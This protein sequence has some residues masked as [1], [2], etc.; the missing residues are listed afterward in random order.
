M[1]NNVLAVRQRCPN[2]SK[3]ILTTLNMKIGLRGK[4]QKLDIAGDVANVELVIQYNY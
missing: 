4:L 2:T 1:P 3:G